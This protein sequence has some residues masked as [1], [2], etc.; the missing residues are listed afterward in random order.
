MWEIRLLDLEART[1]RTV[2]ANTTAPR[3]RPRSPGA[4]AARSQCAPKREPR[5]GSRCGARMGRHA[6]SF[7]PTRRLPTHSGAGPLPG[8]AA[9]RSRGDRGRRRQPAGRG[10]R[11]PVRSATG[12]ARCRLRPIR[13]WDAATFLPGASPTRCS[14]TWRTPS[15]DA[16]GWCRPTARRPPPSPPCPPTPFSWGNSAS[17]TPGAGEMGCT[18]IGRAIAERRRSPGSPRRH[19]RVVRRRPGVVLGP[20]DRR[21]R[22]IGPPNP[23]HGRLRRRLRQ[24]PLAG[25]GGADW[26]DLIVPPTNETWGVIDA[27]VLPVEP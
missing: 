3:R 24:P 7:S 12:C 27:L 23:A 10:R 18:P 21:D 4:A 5:S 16:S 11:G 13:W 22:R 17:P 6:P 19:H 20:P 8:C 9:R 15:T 25:P 14:T 1:S 2:V 26:R